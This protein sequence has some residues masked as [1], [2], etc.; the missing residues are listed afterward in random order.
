MS[1]VNDLTDEELVD[2]L[3]KAFVRRKQSTQGGRRNYQLVGDTYDKYFIKG[4][5][6]CRELRACP[7]LF[8]DSL[9]VNADPDKIFPTFLNSRDFCTKKYNEYI[10][11]YH[12][13]AAVL[14]PVL[15]K[16]LKAQLELGRTLEEVL[17]SDYLDF[18]A[19]FRV[20]ISKEPIP[21]V[22]DKYCAAAQLSF[23]IDVKQ[24]LVDKKLDYKRIYGVR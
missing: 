20:C 16:L 24:L 21:S 12:T 18:P 6:V 23:S 19:W 7:I 3:K 11:T 10:E 22:M 2:E 1:L 17:L 9:F 8:I 14:F 13:K 4:A 15:L 5:E